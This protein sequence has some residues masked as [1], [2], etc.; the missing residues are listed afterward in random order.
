MLLTPL[1]TA[2][3]PLTTHPH[4]HASIT[5]PF[6]SNRTILERFLGRKNPP[7]KDF[8]DPSNPN[9]L[10]PTPGA[11]QQQMPKRGDLDSS[12]FDS[13]TPRT[14]DVS[15]SSRRDPTTMAPALDPQPRARKRW[16]RKMLIREI[17]QR[18]R[19]NKTKKIAR[20]EREHLSKSPL[21]KT[22]IKK[23]GPLARQIA[24]KPIEEAMIQMRF[25][26]KKAAADVL[27]Q[28]KIA[29]DEAMVSRGMGLGLG[30]A[31]VDPVTKKAI[32]PSKDTK[33]EFA[34]MVVEDKKG[35]RR[36]VGDKTGIYVDQAWVGRGR[37]GQALDHR[38]RG[39]INIM[40]LPW[41]SE[42]SLSVRRMRLR[43]VRCRMVLLMAFLFGCRHFGRSKGRSD[44]DTPG[45]RAGAEKI[46]EE[47]VGAIA[48]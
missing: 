41:T 13:V 12:I 42:F 3:K 11:E 27:K 32:L 4:L 19:L 38:A 16:Q 39:Q 6:T 48:G 20:T 21:I 26:A 43:F 8:L 33:E 10:K 40:M 37:Y 31:K 47:G 7:N 30:P 29:R 22:S 34:G 46:D 25:S 14:A 9:L 45:G 23:L 17:Q 28:L 24:G 44:E 2:L 5:L 1:A 36:W 15:L 18:G 35:K